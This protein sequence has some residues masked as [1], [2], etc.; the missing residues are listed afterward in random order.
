MQINAPTITAEGATYTGG[1]YAGK[2]TLVHSDSSEGIIDLENTK[3][4]IRYYTQQTGGTAL[5]NTP[6]N[7]GTYYAGVESNGWAFVE[8]KVS[9]NYQI[10]GGSRAQFSISKAPAT[11]E[12]SPTEVTE[13]YTA[14]GTP[15][16]KVTVSRLQGNDATK[17][18][19]EIYSVTYTYK[20]RADDESEWENEEHKIINPDTFVFMDVGQYQITAKWGAGTV[21]N[22]YTAKDAIYT[23]TIKK[24]E[25][26]SITLTPDEQGTWT[27]AEGDT[28][29]NYTITYGEAATFAV[30][31]TAALD[32]AHATISYKVKD[33]SEKGPDGQPADVLDVDSTGKV[34][35]KQAGTATI[36]VKA[37]DTDNVTGTSVNYTVTVKKAEPTV[38]TGLEGNKLTVAYTGNPITDTEYNKA[39]AA[40]NVVEG[41]AKPTGDITYTFYTDSG[42]QDKVTT[43]GGTD[44]NV[45]IAV[46]TYYMKA[47]YPGD[48]N[49]ESAVSEPV[50]VTVTKAQLTVDAEGHTGT[51][52]GETY[53]PITVKS[54]TGKD[55]D[56]SYE[57]YYMKGDGTDAPAA[58]NEGWSKEL[59]VKDVADSGKYWY[60]V[61]ITGEHANDYAPYI[62]S[63]QVTI[64]AKEL[65]LTGV[66]D[67][68]TKTYDGKT[69]IT[70]DLSITVT[71]GTSDAITVSNATGT[72]DNE[73]AGE[74]KTVTLTLSLSGTEIKWD[75]YSYNGAARP[76]GRSL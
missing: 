60:K 51:Y 8:G 33:G 57:V 17:P 75:N 64:S 30:I 12:F 56:L 67:A 44:K 27:A 66:L 25:D 69:N 20:Y 54:V 48:T 74:D 24:A 22:N 43:G 36:T 6:V 19:T 35:I 58:E 37:A 62:A 14:E 3:S 49:Y 73:N 63:A 23:L 47:S 31:G 55:S 16:Q 46:G 42:C 72:Y 13:I 53:P 71:T 9:T 11:M 50:T 38:N 1:A 29:A 26:Q 40:A 41:A 68:Y 5:E 4:N 70:E 39:T 52:N 61:V 32:T 76:K 2:V 7:A 59:K 10:L 34:T 65:Q 45:P 21:S 28:P 15:L 18:P